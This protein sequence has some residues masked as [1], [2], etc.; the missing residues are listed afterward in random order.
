MWSANNDSEYLEGLTKNELKDKFKEYG[1][2]GYSNK[3]REDLIAILKKHEKMSNK[4][5]KPISKKD[6]MWEHIFKKKGITNFDNDIVITAEE[7]K[8]SKKDCDKVIEKEQFEPRLLCKQDS[9][10][11]LP[12]IFMKNGLN[13]FSIKNGSYVITKGSIYYDL[14]YDENTDIT[15]I[16]K[17]KDVLL[18]LGNSETSMRDN[19]YD[20]G[21]FERFEFGNGDVRGPY[22]GGRH[23][24]SF[25]FKLNGKKYEIRSV[26]IETDG[27][28]KTKSNDKILLIELKGGKV[29]S[30]NIR[31]LYFPYR[32]IYDKDC[33]REIV[34]LF[35]CK[36][37]DDVIHIWKFRFANPEEMTSIEQI[38][39]YKYKLCDDMPQSLRDLSL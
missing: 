32:Y 1:I 36:D 10:E 20:S 9:K 22:L 29:S 12:D 37:K 2:K 3:K 19:L 17:D 21:I 26:Q 8:D 6:L 11:G 13:I 24:V 16:N 38:G 15:L 35:I 31:Q 5:K 34:P 33:S 28:Y 30:F 27:V 7:I 25:D 23:Y 18:S 4:N 14:S 39:Y